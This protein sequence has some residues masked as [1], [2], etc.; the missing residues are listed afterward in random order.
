MDT[1]LKVFSCGSL[2]FE[3]LVGMGSKK[4]AH[5][6]AA[7]SQRRELRLQASQR[8]ELQILEEAE[9]QRIREHRCVI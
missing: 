1:V 6:R 8:R 4:N 2:S 9:Q 5:A 3:I 7:A